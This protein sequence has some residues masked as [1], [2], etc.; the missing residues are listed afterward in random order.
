MSDDREGIE[1]RASRDGH[2]FHERWAARRS[3]QLIFPR[4]EL[5]AIAV[6]GLSTNEASK[7]GAQAQ[8]VADLVLYY[9]SGDSF[10][11][12][13]RLETIQFKYRVG[14]GSVTSSYLKKT[15]QKFADTIIGYEKEFSSASVNKKL[16]FA[17]VTSAAFAPHLWDAIHHLKSGTIPTEPGAKSQY[18]YLETW[19]NERKVSPRRLFS[20]TEFHAA[21]KDLP[22]QNRLLSRTLVDW[23]GGADPHARMRLHA[24]VELVR[25]KAGT[26]GRRNNL[27]KREDILDA[28]D[29]EPEDL[30]PA[31]ARFVDVGT[32]V[33][34]T[35][36]SDAR[37]LIGTA[38]NPVFIFADGGV[39]KTVFVQSLAATMANDYETVVFD[40]FGGGAYRSSDQARHLPKIG[41]VQIANELASHGLCDPMLPTDGDRMGL[42]KAARK[43]LERAA[44]TVRQQSSKSGVLVILDA[45]DNAQIEADDRKEDAFP[46]LL[47]SSLSETPIEGVKLVLTARPHRMAKV[48]GTSDIERFELKPFTEDETRT[49]LADRRKRVSSLEFSTAFARSRGNARVL[50][51]L[52]E[53]WDQNV[54][55]NASKSEITAEELIE[56]KCNRIFRG[57][58]TLGWPDH[59]IREFFAAISLLPPPIPLAE[60]ANAL[61]W[62]ESQVESAASDLAPMLEVVSHGAIFRDEPTET[63]VR[64]TYSEERQ[65]QQAIAQRLQDSQESSTYAAEALPHFLVVIKDSARAYS[66]ANSSAFPGSVQSE[67]GRRRLRMVRLRAAFVLAVDENDL[68]RVLN[69]CM[70]LAEVAAANARGDQ[71]IRRSPA[72]A[73][74]LGDQDA[75]RRLFNDRSGW[76][77]ARD[78]RLTVAYTM[79]EE[80]EE[81]DIHCNRSIGW[82]NWHAQNANEDE[83]PRKAGPAVLDYAAVVFRNVVDG[84]FET[85]DHNLSRWRL[86]FSLSVCKEILAWIE[87]YE[88]QTGLTILDEL[89]VF[90]AS[91]ACRSFALQL[92]LLGEPSRIT[93]TQSAAISRAAGRPALQDGRDGNDITYDHEMAL[94]RQ[95]AQ[96]ALAALLHGSRASSGR[97][98]QTIGGLRPSSYDFGE[99]HGFSRVWV[100]VLVCSLNAWV[101]GQRVS[102]KHLLPREIEQAKWAR[103]KI[104]SQDSLEAFLRTLTVMRDKKDASG[105]TTKQSVEQF[106]RSERDNI[107]NGIS[108]ILDLIKPLDDII[109]ARQPLS[110]KSFSDFLDIWNAQLRPDVHWQA[111]SARDTLCRAVGIGIVNVML[112]HAEH[113]SVTDAERLVALLS[114]NR[115]SIPGKLGVLALLARRPALHDLAGKLAQQLSEDICFDEY[116][117]QR[118]GNYAELSEALMGMSVN[119]AQ[120]YY[121]QGLAQLDQMGGDDYDLVYA[122]LH[123][124]SEQPGGFLKPELGHRLMNLC[125]AIFHHEPGK[126]GWTLFGRA[127]STSIGFPAVYKLVRWFNQDVVDFSYGLPQLVC[128]LA[129]TGTLNPERAAVLLTICEDHGWHEWQVGT[130]LRDILSVA[131][132]EGRERI[133]RLLLNKLVL[134]H[135]FGGWD[136]KWNSLLEVA[137]DYPDAACATDKTLLQRLA[138]E[139]RQRID[140]ENARRNPGMSFSARLSERE[141]DDDEATEAVKKLAEDCNLTS[142]QSI[143]DALRHL[144]PLRRY[145]FD[146][147]EHFVRRLRERCPYDQRAAF[148]SALCEVPALSIDDVIELVIENVSIWGESSKHLLEMKKA[149]IDRLFDARGS[150]LFDLRF[151]G[152][153]RQI[154]R[155][156][157]FCADPA[158]VMR[159]LLE[160]IAK[161]KVE[162]DGEE[163]LQVAT[164]LC[165]LTSRKAALEAFEGLLSGSAAR[166]ADEIGEGS[167]TPALQATTDEKGLVSQI[168]WHLLGDEDA[169]VRWNTARSIEGMARLGLTDDLEA[170]IDLFDVTEIPA[171]R[172]TDHAL[173]FQ[174]SGQ[175]LLMG[176]ARAT[177][178]HREKLA[179]L[180][181]KLQALG[182]REDV[183]VLHKLHIAR[184]LRHLDGT[185]KPSAATKRLWDKT[186]TPAHGYVTKDSWPGPRG[187]KFDFDFDY[188]FNDHNVAG[189]ARLFGITTIEAADAI[190]V[191]I[192]NRWPDAR[193]MNFFPGRKRYRRSSSDRYELYR[194]HIQKH[195]LFS[196]ATR[197]LQTKPVVRRSYENE[198]D[199]PWTEWLRSHDVSFEDGSWLADHK[200]GL[201]EQAKVPVLGQR[202]KGEE[203]LQDRDTLLTKLG[204]LGSEPDEP[205]PVWGHWKSRDGVHIRMSSALV[206]RPGAI[207]KCASFAKRADHELWL[208]HFGADGYDDRTRDANPFEPLIWDPEVYPVGIDEGDK[209]ATP[210][211]ICRARLGIK[212]TRALKLTADEDNRE[213][214]TADGTL[215]LRSQVWGEWENDGQNNRSH[216]DGELLSAFPDWL[217]ATLQDLGKYLVYEIQFNKY[218]S[219][220]SYDDSKG[221]KAIYIGMRT[222]DGKFRAWYARKASETRY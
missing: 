152:T 124:A 138:V 53:S 16:S 159:K 172:S 39:G 71:F 70:K 33:P 149:L 185:A 46:K 31:D 203:T 145:P 142:A 26:G 23:S 45:S 76:R 104:D 176:L 61:G 205:V 164:S 90:A 92:C 220:S 3:L 209:V 64:D 137:K 19:C 208:P 123:Y 218:K 75:V 49:F 95:V 213:W 210:G 179:F 177:L 96:A 121:K 186:H 134:E 99:R 153:G 101:R 111:E 62:S 154:R 10:K 216:D 93:A 175:W 174:N 131:K 133:F 8:D 135:P 195:A 73:A 219:S 106:N 162:L 107:S 144:E 212:L 150:E 117:E 222:G 161:E 74:I 34:R 41:L 110:T 11:T 157:E 4:D 180:K 79:L 14:N 27:I 25:E 191:E 115:F 52:V 182:A 200:D 67:Y 166:I 21:T 190:A 105:R 109:A 60:L 35:A 188:E 98:L 94:E 100:P 167:Y 160:T 202:I 2:T 68:D 29:C 7:P 81:A 5:F 141:S 120:S 42:I 204:L 9:G 114:E 65:A 136:S 129:K 171:L 119:E 30:F 55:G 63:F 193:D 17:F 128:F 20:M 158:F 130:G 47:L 69:L 112:R 50:E 194:E 84:D 147:K 215:A 116:I 12:C 118:A 184:C 187:A 196:A 102:Y 77:G 72:L 87:Q 201:P 217:D 155:L 80:K 32:I 146:S 6:E 189:L 169:Y 192:T 15:I 44:Q 43:R 168:I 178:H 197:L 36:L 82:I 58:H 54:A 78:A 83:F 214:R 56:Q 127:A 207:G 22:A 38:R 85:A 1:V 108:L 57:L 221:V 206:T 151:S 97:L 125:Q 86:Q 91:K 211:P 163:W 37:T 13:R 139:S 165:T 66:L 198:G 48:V 89:A 170:L 183:H 24:L 51:Y 59:E 143:D 132:P 28:L 40:C 140:E 148:T 199:Q 103:R 173:S 181:P 113:V 122:I 88:K 156:S 18:S 126:F